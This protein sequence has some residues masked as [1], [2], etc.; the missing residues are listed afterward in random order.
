MIMFDNEKHFYSKNYISIC[1]LKLLVKIA[2]VM[3]MCKVIQG[4][5][6][7]R[8]LWENHLYSY[9]LSRQRAK[10][11]RIILQ[12]KRNQMETLHDL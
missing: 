4:L 12:I 10:K 11:V 8:S 5:D 2:N 1:S 6:D 9:L 3:P 7:N